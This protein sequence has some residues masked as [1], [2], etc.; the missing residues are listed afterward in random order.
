MARHAVERGL[1]EESGAIAQQLWP[2]LKK[3]G[4]PEVSAL[5]LMT[6]NTWFIAYTPPPPSR[7]ALF[8][9]M[10]CGTR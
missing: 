6:L 1:R 5:V 9:E 2:F 3:P 8:P 10:K 7:A 4:V